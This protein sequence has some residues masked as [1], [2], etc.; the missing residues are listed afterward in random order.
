MWAE[1]DDGVLALPEGRLEPCPPIAVSFWRD[2]WRKSTSNS[3]EMI[4]VPTMCLSLRAT[5]KRKVSSARCGPNPQGAHSW[6]KGMS[7]LAVNKWQ[8]IDN[9]TQ[10]QI[11][12]YNTHLS[13]IQRHI[14]Y[15]EK[16]SNS[17]GIKDPR[18]KTTIK[19][20]AVL[21]KESIK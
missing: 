13:F 7:W 1:V 5:F 20:T 19:L 21:F 9:L 4:K 14:L 6:P 11:D 15:F 17:P 18:I 12:R 16:W 10:R 2:L 8:Q 3:L